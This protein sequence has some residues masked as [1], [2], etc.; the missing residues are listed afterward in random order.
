VGK[1]ALLRGS[2]DPT[3]LGRSMLGA[4]PGAIAGS[5]LLGVVPDAIL[6]RGMGVFLLAYVTISVFAADRV[7]R[8]GRGGAV[9]WGA[10]TGLASGLIGAGGPTSATAMRGYGLDR[11][12][13]VA[14]GAAISVGMQLV[15]LPVFAAIGLLHARDL[16]LLG[17]LCAVALLA[18]Y[19]GRALLA[20]M[21]SKT[22]DRLLLVALLLLGALMIWGVRA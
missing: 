20:R 1:L 15:K 6:R 14:T 4:V 3:F 18:A 17:A 2:L 16:P 8:V 12:G 10:I 7:P 9:G 5:L 13:L 21:E 11:Q 22:F 19:A